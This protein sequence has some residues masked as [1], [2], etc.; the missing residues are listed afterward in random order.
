M[1]KIP[2]LRGLSPEAIPGQ[3][4]TD[5]KKRHCDANRRKQSID[6]ASAA[7]RLQMDHRVASAMLLVMTKRRTGANICMGS[8]RRSAPRDFDNILILNIKSQLRGGC[9]PPRQSPPWSARVPISARD[10]FTSFA[11]SILIKYKIELT[12]FQKSYTLN[13]RAFF[14]RKFLKTPRKSLYLFQPLTIFQGES[15]WLLLSMI[16]A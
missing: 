4:G 9:N 1:K 8:P 15:K 12:E 16:R 7:S 3:V 5:N 13:A 10:C 6:S 14:E 2:N 11:V